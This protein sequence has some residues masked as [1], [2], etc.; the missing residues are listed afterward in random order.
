ME[1]KLKGI[2]IYHIFTWKYST[3]YNFC[4]IKNGEIRSLGL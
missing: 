3:F 2:E 1:A 4:I